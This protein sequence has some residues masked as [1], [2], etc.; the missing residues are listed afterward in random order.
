MKQK[1]KKL[2]CIYVNNFVRIRFILYISRKRREEKGKSGAQT[3]I[4]QVG[5][6]WA[7]LGT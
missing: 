6:L 4:T 1:M 7:F 5:N 3:F 2:V